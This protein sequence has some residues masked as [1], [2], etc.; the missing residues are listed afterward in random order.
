MTDHNSLYIARIEDAT[1]LAAS[2]DSPRLCVG[3]S[4]EEEARAK[5][6]RAVEFYNRTKGAAIKVAPRSVRVI[7]PVFELEKIYA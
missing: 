5:A 1:F 7:S 4:S 2:F 6:H 3:G